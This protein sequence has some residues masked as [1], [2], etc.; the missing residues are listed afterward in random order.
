[1]TSTLSRELGNDLAVSLGSA[2]H[3]AFL[4]SLSTPPHTPTPSG[5]TH[6]V[7]FTY[8]VKRAE[9]VLVKGGVVFL[10]CGQFIV[11]SL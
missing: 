9:L 6:K 5:R 3:A 7:R 2:T 4:L 10:N 1:M 8:R 11:S